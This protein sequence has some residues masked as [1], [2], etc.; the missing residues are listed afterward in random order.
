MEGPQQAQACSDVEIVP[1]ILRKGRRRPEDLGDRDGEQGTGLGAASDLGP[2][3][4]PPTEEC[5]VV[6]Q[7]QQG[8]Y[9]TCPG[10]VERS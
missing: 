5:P 6:M 7:V 9:Q 3:S 10:A 1:C 2:D 8:F 4:V